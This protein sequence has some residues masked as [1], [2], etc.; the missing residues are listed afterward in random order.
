VNTARLMVFYDLDRGEDDEPREENWGEWDFAMLPRQGELVHV[1]REQGSDVV[2]VDRIMHFAVQNPL[3]ET[4]FPS[5]QHTDP[6]IRIA[7][8]TNRKAFAKYT[9]A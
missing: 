3:P 7:L 5:L 2:I 1:L 8:A 6:T 4:S 9:I